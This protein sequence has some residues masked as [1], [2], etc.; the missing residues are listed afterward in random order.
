MFVEVLTAAALHA[1][2]SKLEGPGALD[3]RPAPHLAHLEYL[4]PA[5][6]SPSDG[7]DTD[8]PAMVPGGYHHLVALHHQ[9]LQHL[10]QQHHHHHHSAVLQQVKDEFGDHHHH[11][12]HS[13]PHSNG[14]LSGGGGSTHSRASTP[15]TGPQQVPSPGVDSPPQQSREPMVQTRFRPFVYLFMGNTW[16]DFKK[17]TLV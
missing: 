15:A 16:G 8:N 10:Q 12:Q 4:Q 3:F 17:R 1:A 9:H 5:Q 6:P 2:N 7:D 14:V 11:T 13:P